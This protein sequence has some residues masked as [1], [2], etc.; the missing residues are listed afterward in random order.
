MAAQY[1]THR[2]IPLY[3]ARNWSLRKIIGE[4]IPDLETSI[5]AAIDH[6]RP[7]LEK[8]E[9]LQLE[10]VKRAANVPNQEKR[11][12]K[13]SAV[14]IAYAVADVGVKFATGQTVT[15]HI[16]PGDASLTGASA[17][18]VFGYMYHHVVRTRNAPDRAEQKAREAEWSLR[19]QIT[20]E[21]VFDYLE[22][23]TILE[24]ART[25]EFFEDPSREMPDTGNAIISAVENALNFH[26]DE[27]AD[28]PIRLAFIES[29]LRNLRSLAFETFDRDLRKLGD[30]L[31][32]AIDELSHLLRDQP[33]HETRYINPD[34]VAGKLTLRPLPDRPIAGMDRGE[35]R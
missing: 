12:R 9:E 6:W 35:S 33:W 10:H 25:A 7:H 3:Q 30:S 26:R 13:M 23:V 14:A 4:Y 32:G 11:F 5:D 1:P 34:K 22:A 15:A 17:F 29:S 31:A 21:S 27:V 24:I 16:A 19:H 20:D 8:L 28:S 18:A 2:G